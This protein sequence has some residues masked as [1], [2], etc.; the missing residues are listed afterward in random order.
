MGR[1]RS[2]AARGRAGDGAGRL[3]RGAGNRCRPRRRQDGEIVFVSN[4]ATANP[5]EIYRV[6][7]GAARRNVSRSP[8]ADVALAASPKGRAFAF[9][10]NRAGPGG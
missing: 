10:S 3:E 8:Y 1:R 9:W 4:R 6:A 2:A 5:G 7:P